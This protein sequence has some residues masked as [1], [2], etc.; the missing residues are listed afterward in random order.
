MLEYVRAC[1]SLYTSM[2]EAVSASAGVLPIGDT[3]G[4]LDVDAPEMLYS[5]MQTNTEANFCTLLKMHNF[6]F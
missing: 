1:K 6:S 4:D 2:S 3:S 5:I